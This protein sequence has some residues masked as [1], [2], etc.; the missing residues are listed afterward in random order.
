VERSEKDPNRT[1]KQVQSLEKML[2]AGKQR[3]ALV[4]TNAQRKQLA[5]IIGVLRKSGS[6]ATSRSPSIGASSLAVSP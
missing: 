2:N 4:L 5:E 3:A 6:T 1:S